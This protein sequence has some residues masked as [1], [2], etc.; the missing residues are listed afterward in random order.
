MSEW[1]SFKEH[2]P[3]WMGAFREPLLIFR[4]DM[5]TTQTE[6]DLCPTTRFRPEPTGIRIDVSWNEHDTHWMPLPP[7]PGDE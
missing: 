7:P 4:P 5:I 2:T 6:K 1:I 3:I